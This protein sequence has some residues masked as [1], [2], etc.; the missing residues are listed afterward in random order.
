VDEKSQ[1]EAFS[2]DAVHIVA[3]LKSLPALNI[4]ADQQ[5]SPFQYVSLDLS[6]AELNPLIDL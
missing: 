1:I 3:F 6:S 5:S 2:D 4:N